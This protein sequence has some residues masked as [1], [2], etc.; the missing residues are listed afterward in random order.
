MN[1][2]HRKENIPQEWAK[3][4]EAVREA[5]ALIA[6]A[7]WNGSVSRAYYA[8]YHAVKTLLIAEGVEV[9]SHHAL[10]KMFSLYFVKRGRIES[11]Y[12]RILSRAQKF[13]EESDYSSEYAFTEP[14][15]NEQLREC[16][17][18]LQSVEIL[19]RKDGWLS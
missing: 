12:A 7:L 16:R 11:R 2:K 18:L 4:L 13:R 19:L 9:K 14:D 10:G 6:Q 15:A 8:A 5:E 17:D 1:D 3:A